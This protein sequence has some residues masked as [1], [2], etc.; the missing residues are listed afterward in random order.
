MKELSLHILDI[1]KN[2]VNAGATKIEIIISTAKDGIMTVKIS[3]DGHGMDEE[4]LKKISDPFY[5]TRTTRK[6]GLGIPFLILAAEIAGGGVK[7]TSTKD[8]K[9]HGTTIVA[10]FD[11]NNINFI[12]LGDIVSTI[13]TL[14]HGNP[15]IDIIFSDISEDKTVSLDTRQLKEVLGDV[16]IGNYEVIQWIKEYLLEQYETKT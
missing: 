9:D 14:I 12:P 4:T 5:T 1:A 7:I 11:T 15:E 3:D 6:V 8:E 13:T 16:S 10:T 2:S